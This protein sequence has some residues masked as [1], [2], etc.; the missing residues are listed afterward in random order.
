MI[1]SDFKSGI[2]IS[3]EN[4]LP[5]QSSRDGYQILLLLYVYSNSIH[6]LVAPSSTAIAPNLYRSFH[7]PGPLQCWK[8]YLGAFIFC[9]CCDWFSQEQYIQTANRSFS[10]IT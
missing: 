6:E 8:F 4:Y 5:S 7:A 3:V 2:F 1:G 9:N 10:F